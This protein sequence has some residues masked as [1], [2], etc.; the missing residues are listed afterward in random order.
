MKF[1]NSCNDLCGL[2]ETF[3]KICNWPEKK[4]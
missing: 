1:G 3:R 4:R 2:E